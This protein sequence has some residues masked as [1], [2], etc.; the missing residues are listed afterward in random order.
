MTGLRIIN[1][2]VASMILLVAGGCTVVSDIQNQA[3]ATAIG[4]DFED[5]EWV[6]YAQVINFST[7]GSSDQV[8]IGEEQPV[9]IGSGRGKTIAS[10]LTNI[11]ESSQLNMFWGH[12]KAVV[13]TEAALK[14]D[15]EEIYSGI[16]RYRE[17]RYTV[18]VYGTKM[19]IRDVLKQKSLFNMSPLYTKIF[20]GT[21]SSAEQS[22]ILPLTANR[23][24]A[25]LNEPGDP[26]AIPSIGLDN[27]SWSEDKKPKPM[28][29]LTGKYYFHGKK[30]SSWMSLE[31]LIGTRWSDENL[32]RT[33]LL[34][35]HDGEKVALL[36][37]AHPMIHTQ[38]IMEPTGTRFKLHVK[39]HGY[40]MEM[41]RDASM[42]EIEQYA[43]EA[44]A[45]EVTDTFY[46]GVKH[47]CDPFAVL[48]A[49]YRTN[50]KRFHEEVTGDD[51]ALT[52]RSLAGVDVEVRLVNT[53]KYKGTTP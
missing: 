31:E 35:R 13:I 4:I 7:V 23:A 32:E 44:I 11:G 45:K 14:K 29:K 46:S 36:R 17:V 24:I 40:V 38:T 25:R 22:Y 27:N 37:M 15:V 51:F 12:V 6:A 47:K 16:N 3:Y 42:K 49:L 43:E 20:T 48:Q 9:W 39:V 50:P 21:Q 26:A 53:G 30:M 5:G 2:L 18:Y 1:G 8:T 34:I 33:S 52:N 10:A 41:M 19:D 28:F